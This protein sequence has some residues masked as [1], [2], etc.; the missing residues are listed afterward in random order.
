MNVSPPEGRQ[1]SERPARIAAAQAA[2]AATTR[3]I[4]EMKRY[5]AELELRYAAL[6]GSS[7]WRALEPARALARRLRGEPAP[8]AFR[9]IY[10]GHLVSRRSG[11]RYTDKARR[12][13]ASG[14]AGFDA[15]AI[16]DLTALRDNPKADQ[17]AR[18]QA[19]RG[20]LLLAANAAD[21]AAR[22]EAL[23]A[24][25]ALQHWGRTPRSLIE[26]RIVEASLRRSLGLPVQATPTD[27]A[28]DDPDLLLLL[29]ANAP[30]RI[31]LISRAFRASAGVTVASETLPASIDSLSAPD[32]PG[33]EDGPLVSVI[34]PAFNNAATLET[35]LRSLTRQTW[36]ALE[37]LVADDASTDAT[38]E[39]VAACAA[40]DPRI[41]LIRLP[42]NGGA[43]AARNA[44]LAEAAGELVT[45][46]DADD[47]SHPARIARQARALLGAP[48]GVANVSRWARATDDLVF[49]RRP[50]T[51]GV[52][53]FNSSSI[54]FRRKAVL[55]RIG[56]WDRVRF[57][58]DTEFWRRLQTAFGAAATAEIPELLAVGRV[59][60]GSLSRATATAYAGAK[61]GAR[62]SYARSYDAWHA[63]ALPSELRLPPVGGADRPFAVPY[64][65][66]AGKPRRGHFDAVL[67]SDFRHVGGTTASNHQE[68]IAQVRAG[69]RTAVVQIDRYGYDVDRGV[70]PAIKAMIDE[71]AVEELVFGDDVSADAVVIRFP[72]IFSQP[73]RHLPTIAARSV[74]VVVNQSP[75]RIA[76]EAP[77]YSIHD[78]RDNVAAW[79]G[80][81]GDWVP[82]GP[83][84]RDAL[85]ADDQG[86]LLTSEDWF[87][88][89][90]VNAWA[91]ER[92]GWVDSRPV[93][94]RHGRDAIEKWPSQ[95]ADILAAYPDDGSMRVRILGGANVA[96]RTIGRLPEAWQVLEFNSVP[97][98]DFLAGLDF[99]VFFPHE[100]RIEA[101]GRTIIEA[102]A[103]G[104]ATILPPVFRPLFG[105]A[106]IYCA[107]GE[108]RDLVNGLYADRSAYLRHTARADEV[109]RARFGYEQHIA[110]LRRAMAGVR[111]EG[112][113]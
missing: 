27:L 62:L 35:S 91:A 65:M 26:A 15:A 54:T 21:P 85:E 106:A 78:A 55:E 6:L 111:T 46:Q 68:L 64:V 45:C 11:S 110:R 14:K 18:A 19:E 66:R 101:F 69:L 90:D 63:A 100:E 8:A 98:R 75:R 104:C 92:A 95:A 94:G 28:H 47:W 12:M 105:E 76:G 17:T 82:I 107:P 30:D 58:G 99:F 5:V 61:V 70:N 1:D 56:G 71:G 72:A 52:V 32:A 41:R 2:Y 4:G 57:A 25:G 29:A 74:R 9:P 31:D 80:A 60:E 23:T 51:T 102:M 84:V 24:L 93:I 112:R 87:N 67:A 48:D 39:I 13:F 108:V 38:P 109:V 7:T 97:P 53:H 113:A 103:S 86:D 33:S 96:A 83:Q 22:A 44:A 50:F 73:Q 20:A 81:P 89:I 37:I 59:R 42:E 79:L 3:E 43:Y 88:I 16:A 34:V 36:G 40:A 10:A 77:F 49:E